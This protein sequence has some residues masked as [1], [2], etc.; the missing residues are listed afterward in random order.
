ME[1]E[2]G[3]FHIRDVP[4]N[5]DMLNEL[6]VGSPVCVSEASVAELTVTISWA[7]VND[8]CKITLDGVHVALGRCRNTAPAAGV[9]A[10]NA[11]S[12]KATP[13][14]DETQP[15]ESSAEEEEE[16]VLF[17]ANWIDIIISRFHVEFKNICLDIASDDGPSASAI[18][19]TI[20][21]INYF[22]SKPEAANSHDVNSVMSSITAASRSVSQAQGR[23]RPAL[24]SVLMLSS[25]EAQNSKV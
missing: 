19:L 14:E 20:D 1:P 15:T 4:L 3:L 8:G 9:G 18:R 11:S 16:G 10:D 17:L 7:A 12:P 6:L 21:E 5:C 24:A 23:D 22:N 13:A 25:Q 2:T